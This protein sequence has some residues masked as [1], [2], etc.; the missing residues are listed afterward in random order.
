MSINWQTIVR[1]TL[2][3]QACFVCVQIQMVESTT[4]RIIK[5]LSIYTYSD[6]KS[7][8]I[9]LLAQWSNF[10]IFDAV[11]L[12]CLLKRNSEIT[13]KQFSISC[14]IVQDCWDLL[15]L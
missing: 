10:V 2:L 3:L 4:V 7:C 14:E 1:Q 9:F 11:N 15:C 5:E 8:V 6:A 13:F 12:F